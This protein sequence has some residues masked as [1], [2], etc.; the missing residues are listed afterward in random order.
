MAAIV[1]L[2]FQRESAEGFVVL[3]ELFRALDI[4]YIL[5]VSSASVP[6]R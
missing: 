1:V 2:N 3:S 6:L 4:G 5:R